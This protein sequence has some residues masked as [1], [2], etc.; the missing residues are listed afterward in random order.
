MPVA[1]I[2]AYAV[3]GP[4]KANPRFLI[5]LASAVDSGVT[6][7]TSANDLSR[8]FLGAGANDHSRSES[9]SGTSSAA[10]ALRIAASI[11]A[12]LRTI[13]ASLSSRSTS[14][15]S[16]SATAGIEKSANAARNA[17]RLRRMVIQDSPDWNASRVS[18]S[19]IRSSPR[20]GWPHSLS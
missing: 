6:A 12:R 15:A 20:S 5:A 1:C 18:R 4:T 3:V 11:L 14:A 13:P 7:G 10:R 2:R 9:P 17:G 8:R 16:K 19:N